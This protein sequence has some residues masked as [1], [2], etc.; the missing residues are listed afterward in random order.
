MGPRSALIWLLFAVVAVGLSGGVLGAKPAGL[1]QK[2]EKLKGHVNEKL[3][4]DKDGNGKG[5]GKVKQAKGSKYVARKKALNDYYGKTSKQMKYEQQSRVCSA[6]AF[7]SAAANRDNTENTKQ[8]CYDTHCPNTKPEDYDKNPCAKDAKACIDEVVVVFG[9]EAG[10]TDT[11]TSDCAEFDC[12]PKCVKQVNALAGK[13]AT[14]PVDDYN[15]YDGSTTAGRRLAASRRFSRMMLEASMRGDHNDPDFTPNLDAM[16]EVLRPV[17]EKLREQARQ[18]RFLQGAS[19]STIID[20]DDDFDTEQEEG[21]DID[22]DERTNEVLDRI[23]NKFDKKTVDSFCADLDDDDFREA[24]VNQR[25]S[26]MDQEAEQ[27]S[28]STLEADDSRRRRSLLNAMIARQLG[29]KESDVNTAE[30]CVLTSVTTPLD[31]RKAFTDDTA[32]FCCSVSGTTLSSK[33]DSVAINCV[34]AGTGQL[35]SPA[36]SLN[37]APAAAGAN[38][39]CT[40]KRASKAPPSLLYDL[41]NRDMEVDCVS[42]GTGLC[43]IPNAGY[44]VPGPKLPHYY[45]LLKR[46]HTGDGVTRNL[47]PPE[48]SDPNWYKRRVSYMDKY[49]IMK[50]ARLAQYISLTVDTVCAAVK[51]I[52]VLFVAGFGGVVGT[53]VHPAEIPCAILILIP[54]TAMTIY[55]NLLADIDTQNGVIDATESTLMYQTLHIVGYNQEQGLD[56]TLEAT[57]AAGDKVA[58]AMG[59]ETT[60]IKNAIT[61]MGIEVTEKIETENAQTRADLTKFINEVEADILDDIKILTDTVKASQDRVDAEVCNIKTKVSLSQRE[62]D[63]QRRL[64]LV[65]QGKMPG[66]VGSIKDPNTVAYKQCNSPLGSVNRDGSSPLNTCTQLG[67]TNI[68]STIGSWGCDIPFA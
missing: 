28:P 8:A 64:L 29:A 42:P 24:A 43:N 21:V 48:G 23:A 5:R 22:N 60:K 53:D 15:S 57:Q 18:R 45:A 38:A 30:S 1:V 34:D 59:D 31:K 40:C 35:A 25:K 14:Y 16:P 54:D 11:D 62:V 17:Y 33:N 6:Q 10:A 37:V 50:K 2:R 3:V 44:D 63:Y 20:E 67:A 39:S 51:A 68:A 46:L 19:T 66:Y 47:V 41:G 13:A 58:T 56:H 26:F 32:L 12:R 7:D 36:L 52:S 61:A 4:N 65:P 9:T 55:N 49:E 27:P